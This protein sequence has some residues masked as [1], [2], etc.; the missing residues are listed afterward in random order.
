MWEPIA[1]SETAR[2]CWSAIEEIER[3]LVERMQ[4]AQ[5]PLLADGTAGQAIFFTYLDL[6]RQGSE[7]ADHALAA[8]GQSIDALPD[9]HLPPSLYGG[10]CGVGW[11]VE[12]L[13]R[14]LFDGDERLCS[15]IDEALSGL[16]SNPVGR[17]QYDLI[18]GL[19]GFGVYLLERLPNP[20]AARLL[21]R[22]LDLLDATAEESQA[23]TTWHTQPEWLPPRQR[24][25]M[26]EGCH[27]LGVAHGVPGVIGFLAAAQRE[28][29]SDPRIPRLAEGAVRWLLSQR[30]PG[31]GQSAFPS[32]IVPGGEP[33]PTRTAWCYGDLGI[34]AVLLSAA[35]SFGRPSWEREAVSLARTAASR[36]VEAVRASDP[37]ICH[38]A[39]GVGHIFNRLCQQTGDPE[40][41]EAALA[42]FERALAMRRPGE[43]IAGFL[44]WVAAG[45]DSG[46]LQGEPGFLTGVAGIGLALLA[47]V[48]NIEP[49]WDRVMLLSLPSQPSANGQAG[50][51]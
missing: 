42:W 21:A 38:G 15:A 8:L 9:R 2:R 26:P 34:A 30:Q 29:G 36:S 33:E 20:D 43:G 6:A 37:G 17:P 50:A 22:A 16:L 25:K 12:H 1:D 14:E 44:S 48:T 41:K 40:L 11:V 31:D 3:G 35:R 28:T 5:D 23:G 45:P 4:R 10:F 47:A 39:A 49:A 32:V 7:A 24:E 46:S 19:A 27:N 18:S 51:P 13:T